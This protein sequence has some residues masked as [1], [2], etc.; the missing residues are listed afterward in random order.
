MQQIE[1]R[2]QFRHPHA[3]RHQVT[4]LQQRPVKRFSVESYQH[5]ALGDSRGELYQQGMLFGRLAYQELFH[6]RS[7]C[8]T[9]R[10]P[11]KDSVGTGAPSEATGYV[12]PDPTVFTLVT[13]HPHILSSP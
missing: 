12:L 11:S 3:S 9:P 6:L 8:I 5:R 2:R 10:A 1:M 13:F 7:A 4:A